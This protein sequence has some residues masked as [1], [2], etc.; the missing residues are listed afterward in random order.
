MDTVPEEGA[1]LVS[2]TGLNAVRTQKSEIKFYQ[3]N[4]I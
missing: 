1:V 3:I 4:G 2:G